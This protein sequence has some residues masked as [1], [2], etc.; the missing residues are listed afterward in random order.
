MAE[1]F[2]Q[3]APQT[4][5]RSFLACIT[6][7][8]VLITLIA[9]TSLFAGT[10]IAIDAFNGVDDVSEILRMLPDSIQ[11]NVAWLANQ[12]GF[13]FTTSAEITTAEQQEANDKILAMIQI[14]LP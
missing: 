9:I 8:R 5:K 1:C 4:S 2:V 11:S 12:I 14:F 6:P 13:D 10:K 7:K 3:S